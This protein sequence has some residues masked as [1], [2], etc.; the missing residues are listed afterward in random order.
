[1]STAKWREK[2]KERLRKYRRDWFQRNKEHARKRVMELKRER[3]SWFQDLKRGLK[4]SLCEE[5]HP[6]CLEFHHRD[7]DEKTKTISSLAAG[8]YSEERILLEI[9]K[10]DVLCANCHRK[11]HWPNGGKTRSKDELERYAPIPDAEERARRLRE[12]SRS[13]KPEKR[14]QARELRRKGMP[15]RE[16]QRKLGVSASSVWRWIRDIAV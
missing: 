3:K 14:K 1:M 5:D 15:Y 6:A 12:S 10:C 11:T 7:P 9:K 4:C 16:I 13:A 2:N 8:T